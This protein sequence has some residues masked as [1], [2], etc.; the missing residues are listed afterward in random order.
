MM[1]G[2]EELFM[3]DVMMQSCQENIQDKR[4]P[5]PLA[6]GMVY[7]TVLILMLIS[8]AVAAGINVKGENYF[9]LM[10][11]VQLITIGLPPTAYLIWF[12]KDIRYSLRLKKTSAA[13]ILL[14][15][16][17]A[18]FGYGAITFINLLWV[19]FLSQF[20]TP[21]TVSLPPIETGR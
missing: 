10:F 6:G 3:H 1:K 20:G 13:E 15:I 18:V 11:L 9:I 14:A 17:M 7:L 5:T 12:K 16:G 8:S 2:K 4:T 21:Q 19:L